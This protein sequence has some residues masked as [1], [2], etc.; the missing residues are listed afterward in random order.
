MKNFSII[1]TS[2]AFSLIITGCLIYP[3]S[4]ELNSASSNLIAEWNFDNAPGNLAKT[5]FGSITCK[6]TDT[7]WVA[8]KIKHAME[9]NGINSCL[10]AGDSNAANIT[11]G[12]T[13]SFWM[14]PFSWS[15]QYSSG[16]ISK[17]KTDDAMGYVIYADGTYPTK[18]NLR[19]RGALGGE[20]MLKSASDVEEDV[21]QHWT[22]TH[23]PKTKTIAWYKNGKLDIKYSNIVIGDTTNDTPLQL[24][25]SHT[26]NGFYDGILDEVRIYNRPLSSAEI[27]SSF[28]SAGKSDVG[29][30]VPVKWRVINTKYPTNDVITA[31]CTVQDAGAKGDGV[32]DDTEAFQSAM[33]T[34]TKL[35][36][37]TVFVPEGKYV[38]KGNLRIPTGVTLR[39]EWE[40]PTNGKPFKG[41]I[42]MAY[43]GRGE[44]EGRPLIALRQCSG[45][46]GMTIWYP[47]QK[48]DD[49]VPYP[50]TIQQMGAASA[51]VSNV[52]LVNTYQGIR[53]NYGSYLHYFHNVYGAPLSVGIE[54]GFVSDT[55]RV[56]MIDFNPDYWSQSGLPGAPKADGPH[57]SW[58]RNNGTAMLFRRYEWIYSA[59]VSLRGYNTGIKMVNSEVMGETNG[60]MYKYEITDCNTAIDI[61]NANFAGISFTKCLLQ[62]SDYGVFTHDTFN[63]RLLFHSC[64]IRG[65]KKSALL[66]GIDNQSVFFRHCDFNNEIVRI[67]GDLTIMG[68]TINSPGNHITL[69]ENANAVT[70][71][72]VVTN[73][74]ARII[75]N[76]KYNKVIISSKKIQPSNMPDFPVLADKTLKPAK[77]NLYVIKPKSKYIKDYTAVIQKELDKAGKNGGGIVFITGGIY[78]VRGNLVVPSGVELRGVYDVEHHSRGKGSV[79]QV[80][81]NRNNEDADP[82]INMKENSGIKGLTFYYPEQYRNDIVPYPYLIQGTGK[83]IYAVNV[84]AMNPYKF[85]DFKTYRCDNHHI[86]YAA[87]S[88]L[89]VGIA[90][91]GG[92]EGGIVFNTQFNPNNWMW[93]PFLDSVG[94]SAEDLQQRI[95]YP[96]IYQ[97]E[98]LDAFIFGN[99]TNQLQYQNTVFGSRNGIHFI[100]ENGKGASGIVMGHGSDGTLVPMA[101]D[102]VGAEG[103]DVINS[104]LV[105]MDCPGIDPSP[106]K[107]YISCGKELTSQ[108]R[109]YN[110]TLWGMPYNSATVENGSLNIELSS[111]CMYGPFVVNGGELNLSDTFLGNMYQGDSEFTVN[112]NGK[113]VHIGTLTPGL[114]RTDG[115]A[116]SAAI[117]SDLFNY[118]NN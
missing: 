21:W 110:T 117:T 92:S 26:W 62:G 44:T 18:I 56:D 108:V 102:G 93:S 47:E 112:N 73:G 68:C 90:V 50:F 1:F 58:I 70:I 12:F 99:C 115:N 81:A 63:S 75:N 16:I 39:G 22:V 23:D 40:K 116:P 100:L 42:L 114:I 91:G 74:D 109:M 67:R 51:T 105:S 35:G 7:K 34:M 97:Y 89:K 49:I 104:Q 98:N 15:D 17:K 31:G 52:T 118:R 85:M 29:S 77:E 41:S 101:F 65:G 69:G 72:D 13:I 19:L 11:G 95:S 45:I 60:Q 71:A 20:A 78:P 88:P 76:S 53:T 80:F 36:G 27:K 10:D 38:I 4:A 8:G 87:G 37:G 103:I 111:F 14:K 59:F 84:T 2:I 54:I 5:D 46:I 9:F 82:F 113:V 64:D 66:D 25:H 43:A 3:A 79:I 83:N 30:N 106:Q 32:T 24:G 57:V 33:N 107:R 55:G 48:P 6:I 86:E 28:I 61:V 94:Q 96:W